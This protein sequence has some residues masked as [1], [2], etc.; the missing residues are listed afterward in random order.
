V[1]CDTAWLQALFVAKD[2]A[3][4]LGFLVAVALWRRLDRAFRLMGVWLLVTAVMDFTANWI[5]CHQD[6]ASRNLIIQFWFPMSLPLLFS[7]LGAVQGSVTR[8]DTL[9]L[10]A[11]GY[12]FVWAV[13]IIYWEK[14]GEIPVFT[15]ALHTVLLLAAAAATLV[16]RASLSRHDLWDDPGFVLSTALLVFGIPTLFLSSFARTWRPT[17]PEWVQAYW[18]MH[19]V[20]TIICFLVIAFSMTMVARH[21][22]QGSAA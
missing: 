5:G 1:N 15:A 16:R 21:R 10:M 19:A 4:F 13:L 17:H 9:R 6:H 7:A 3:T 8:R 22:R 11:L 2:G 18:G 20:V 14:P 12:V